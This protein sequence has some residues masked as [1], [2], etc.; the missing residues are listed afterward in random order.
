MDQTLS[1]LFLGF[2]VAAYS[3]LELLIVGTAIKPR[4]QRGLK[5]LGVP[6]LDRVKKVLTMWGVRSRT[7]A[8]FGVRN[9]R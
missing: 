1:A 2:V 8:G 4:I 6:A 7:Q 5:K 9:R 3:A